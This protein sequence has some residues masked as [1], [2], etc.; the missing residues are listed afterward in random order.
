L[1][2]KFW[3]HN[4]KTIGPQCIGR[5]QFTLLRFKQHHRMGVV[6]G[7][8]MNLPGKK[9]RFK[10]ASGLQNMMRNKKD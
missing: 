7:R 1:A 6:S 10:S 8:R 5:N 3:K 9:A 2:F 4:A